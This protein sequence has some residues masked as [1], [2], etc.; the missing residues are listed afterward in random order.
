[1]T[2][3]PDTENTEPSENVGGAVEIPIEWEG[4]TDDEKE[5]AVDA[6]LT[7]VADKAGIDTAAAVIENTEMLP[8]YHLDDDS[9]IDLKDDECLDIE[10]FGH[11]HVYII[12]SAQLASVI[13]DVM[14][15]ASD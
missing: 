8:R 5:A 6:M 12:N 15:Q 3:T 14:G 2:D 11:H 13:R 4:M 9:P 1:M 10:C 7:V